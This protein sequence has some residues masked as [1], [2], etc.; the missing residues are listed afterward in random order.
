MFTFRYTGIEPNNSK[1]FFSSIFLIPLISYL[2]LLTNDLHHFHYA[3]TS[4]LNS[5]S[6]PFI[7]IKI[8]PWYLVNVIYS[9]ALFSTGLLILWKRFRF[10]NPHYKMQTKLIL[11]AGTLPI[12]LNFLYQTGTIRVFTEID[13]TPFAFLFTYLIL[14]Y[15]IIKFN[16]F[17]IKPLQEESL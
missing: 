8:G 11:L 2:I 17:N 13:L 1:L 12:L 4:I 16:L 6:F 10:A 15:A 14:A 3:E 5:G 9:Y 7:K